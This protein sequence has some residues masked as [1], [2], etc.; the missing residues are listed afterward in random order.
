MA[1]LPSFTDAWSI[2]DYGDVEDLDLGRLPIPEPASGEMVVE[3]EA[4]ALNPLDLKLIAGQMRAA[5]P[6]AFPFVPGNDICGRVVA[7]G[8]GVAGHKDG[9]RVVAWT[10]KNGAMARYVICAEGPLTAHVPEALSAAE[11]ASLPEVGMTAQT[12]MRAAE[13]KAGDTVLIIGAAGGV[14][15]MLCQLASK[16][17]ARV[18]AT[19]ES[20]DEALARSLGAAET[21]NHTTGDTVDLLKKNHPDG[22]GVVV[23]LINMQ[24]ALLASAGA[25]ATGGKLISTLGG[26]D[27]KS[28]PGQVDV[29]YIHM[30]PQPGD[31][32]DLVTSLSSGSLRTHIVGRFPFADVPQAYRSLRDDHPHG[33]IV[34]EA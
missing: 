21:I 12:V 28:F 31:L 17:G 30:T 26:P 25:V 33:K 19:A 14:G 27:P 10:P 9:D 7:V 6:T 2:Q 13:L 34:V 11:L 5:M 8:P 18:I 16:A 3:V 4:A 24:D 20:K 1:S 15:Q 23:D 32:D 29:R 22:V